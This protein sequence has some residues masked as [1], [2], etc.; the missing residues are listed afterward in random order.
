MC[1]H[2]MALD[3]RDYCTVYPRVE[4]GDMASGVVATFVAQ[5]CNVLLDN[6]PS[7][8]ESGLNRYDSN[9]IAVVRS[10][11]TVGHLCLTQYLTLGAHAQQGLQQLFRVSVCVSVR[12][13]VCLLF[14]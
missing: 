2:V 1:V 9:S 11:L 13:S 5:L 3:A 8:A 4:C 10:G 6:Y 12:L 14:W 7:V